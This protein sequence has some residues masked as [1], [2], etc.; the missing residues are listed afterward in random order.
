MP[1]LINMPATMTHHRQPCS[2]DNEALPFRHPLR[3]TLDANDIPCPAGNGEARVT[4]RA[5]HDLLVMSRVDDFHQAVA[6]RTGRNGR[7][8]DGIA[9]LRQAYLCVSCSRQR[10]GWES[11]FPKTALRAL[12]RDTRRFVCKSATYKTP[13]LDPRDDAKGRV[14]GEWQ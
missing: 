2:R 1:K 5:D 9:V 8:R 13:R 6:D 3:L 11:R 7:W 10:R 12:W 4:I 14:F